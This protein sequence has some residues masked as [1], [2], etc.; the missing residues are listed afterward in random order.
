MINEINESQFHDQVCLMLRVL[1]TIM[2]EKHFALKGGTAIN[3]FVRN[4]PRLSVDIDLTYLPIEPRKDTLSQ[5]NTSLVGVASRIEYN[6]P[7]IL[8]EVKRTQATDI[9]QIF[10]KDKKVAIKAE[11]NHTLR[12]AVHVPVKVGLC[13]R[14][15]T[16]FKTFCKIPCL[17]FEDLY[18]GKICAALDRQ[19]PRDLFDI[20]HL[21]ENEG[22][23]EK[24]RKTFIVYLISHNRPIAEILKPNYLNIQELF[25]KEFLGM[26]LD[27]ASY[28]ELI[29]AR[30]ALIKLINTGLTKE[31]KKFLISIKEGNPNWELLGLGNF[32]NFP[33]IQWKLMNIKNMNPEKHQRSLNILKEKLGV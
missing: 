24:L 31:E 23:S 14:A 1:P 27:K 9:K 19:H 8:V 3:M 25:E 17:S 28:D 2:E 12:G 4:M 7:D 30:E 18:A 29:Y 10:I 13:Q 22:V 32:Q 21:I 33:A 11:V 20:K 6:F 5:I 15:Q 26:T 16:V